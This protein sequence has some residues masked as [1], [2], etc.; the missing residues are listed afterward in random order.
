LF[1]AL[2]APSVFSGVLAQSS[3]LWWE[4]DG[5]GEGTGWIVRELAS[6]PPTAVR[7]HLE[8]GR[9]EW[10]L[11]EAH[12]R[13]AEALERAGTPLRYVEYEGG[14]DAVCWRGGLAEGL[15]DLAPAVGW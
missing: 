7:V 9:Q 15:L 13:L 10:V 12:K 4:P 11:L 3:S 14:H 5:D 8:V 2:R 6:T 1:A